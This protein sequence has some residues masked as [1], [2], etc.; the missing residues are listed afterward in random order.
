MHFLNVSDGSWINHTYYSNNC[1]H[2][3]R[4]ELWCFLESSPC[5]FIVYTGTVCYLGSIRKQGSTVDNIATITQ[6]DV[7]FSKGK[8]P[9]KLPF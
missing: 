3:E 2:R 5:Q 7:W 6:Q 4:C 8:F 9:N 1:D